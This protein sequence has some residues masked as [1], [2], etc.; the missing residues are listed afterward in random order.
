MPA[1]TQFGVVEEITMVAPQGFSFV[2][3]SSLRIL[4]TIELAPTSQ[5]QLSS[6]SSRT[7]PS[8][9]VESKQ[10]G[11]TVFNVNYNKQQQ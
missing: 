5:Q 3:Y 1:L 9:D 10:A 11:V 8:R 7:S 2:T 6:S 4:L